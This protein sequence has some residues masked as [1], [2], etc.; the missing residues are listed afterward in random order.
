MKALHHKIWD[1]VPR[2]VMTKLQKQIGHDMASKIAEQTW[3]GGSGGWEFFRQI[4][5]QVATEVLSKI[6][7]LDPT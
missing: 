6:N 2:R 4:R 1:V 3:G 7:H 5:D